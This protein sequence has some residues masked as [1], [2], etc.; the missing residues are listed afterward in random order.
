MAES[1]KKWKEN[2]PILYDWFMNHHLTWPSLCCR[3]GNMK[4]EQKFKRKQQ[5]YLSERT[6]GSAPNKMMVITADITNPR[7]AAADAISNFSLNKPNPCIIPTCT[8]LHPGEVNKIRELPQNPSIIVTHTDAPEL[9]VWNT[10]RQKNRA[11][12]KKEEKFVLSVADLMLTGHTHPAEFAVAACG[13]APLVAS[14]GQDKHV[15]VWNLGDHDGGSLLR[16]P[17][18][19]PRGLKETAPALANRNTLRGHSNTIEDVVFKPGSDQE[20]ASV[21][22]D[23]SVRLWDM[24]AG[25]GPSLSLVEA[26]GNSD[27]HCLDWNSFDTFLLA[28]GAA[29]GTLKVWDP[30]KM[31]SAKD[32]LFSFTEHTNP[33]MRVEWGPYKPGILASGGEDDEVNVWNLNR[34]KDIGDGV[35]PELM[36]KHK[37]HRGSVADF[38]WHPKDP[39][40]MLSVSESDGGTLQIWRL[41]ELIWRD[42]EEVIEML[43][44]YKEYILTGK[45][46]PKS[47]A[48]KGTGSP[49]QAG[50]KRKGPPSS[51]TAPALKKFAS[52]A[53]PKPS[54]EATLP[55]PPPP[56]SLTPA[57]VAIKVS[58][59]VVSLRTDSALSR[60]TLPDASG[61]APMMVDG[62]TVEASRAGLLGTDN[63][64][65]GTG[66]SGDAVK[67]ERTVPQASGVGPLGTKSEAEGPAGPPPN[68]AGALETESTL[69]EAAGTGE[70]GTEGDPRTTALDS[71]AVPIDIDG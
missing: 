28:T 18:P 11:G 6:D 44:P 16:K 65:G 10:E 51:K 9:Y 23:Y 32:A 26:H 66:P 68:V 3:W 27:V 19:A 59:P 43:E 48:A 14:G 71:E 34:N 1:F 31:S 37:G 46:P 8:I 57:A 4:D 52:A 49:L 60:G 67:M 61:A 35:A 58:E 20:L 5:I 54:Q 41:S 42:K 53:P 17:G 24:R 69:P 13:A 62:T 50:Q 22:D 47:I 29:D 40:T 55:R 30:R 38:Q 56:K 36:F 39:Y 64:L 63:H 2:V 15:L 12:D 7:V 33:I 45:N 21:G 25:S 70:R